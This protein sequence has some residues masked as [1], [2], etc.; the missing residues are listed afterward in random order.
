MG[1]PIHK[2]KLVRITLVS[3]DGVTYEVELAGADTSGMDELVAGLDLEFES[4]EV[5]SSTLW[6][7]QVSTGYATVKLEA[8]GKIVKSERRKEA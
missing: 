4:R 7:Q 3:D 2:A 1:N 8:Y 5:P 6:R